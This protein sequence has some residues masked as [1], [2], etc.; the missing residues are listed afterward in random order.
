[1]RLLEELKI[2]C[3]G[4]FRLIHMGEPVDLPPS[5]KARALLSYLIFSG[6]PKRREHLCEMFWDTPHDPKG[7]LRWALSRLRNCLSESPR[8]RL[9]AD[10]ETITFN[11]KGLTSPLDH[12]KTRLD[13]L[14][15]DISELREIKSDL[16]K[17]FLDGVDLPNLSQ[18]SLWL[19]EQRT[20]VSR[21]KG[22]VLKRNLE[23]PNSAPDE[24]EQ[25]ARDWLDLE[26]FNPEAARTLVNLLLH[27]NATLEAKTIKEELEI[28]FR[29]AGIDFDVKPHT[30]PPLS[31]SI[32]TPKPQ[33][34]AQEKHLLARQKIQFCKTPTGV[35]LAYASVGD[36]PPLVKAANWLTHLEL[37]WTAPIWSPLYR[38]LAQDFT[39]IRYD[40]RGNGLSDWDVDELSQETF[41]KDLECVVDTMGLEKFPL[42]GIS[43]GAAVSIEY[44]IRHPERVSKLI[45]F[46]GYP[47]GWKIDASPEIQ[48]HN[49]AMMTLTKTGW[50][51][52]N[53]AY[54]HVFSST[55]MPSAS[56]EDLAWFDDFQRQTTS[57][58]NAVKFLEAFASIDVRHHLPNL[59]VPTL[60][61]HSRGDQRIKWQTGR[62]IA[63]EIPNAEFVSLDSDNH[64]L[65]EGEPAADKFIS[66]VREFLLE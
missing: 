45:L 65:L 15:L 35:N 44:A 6:E 64:L 30:P 50:G 13:S 11:M 4:E 32:P 26:P 1:M 37:D 38:E 41:V 51:Q 60:V 22:Q 20:E 10:R 34:H 2:N 55:F 12:M 36:G 63:A 28:R 47:K 24:S 56:A 66:A 43:Q 27:Q 59:K 5:K 7:S 42:L 8:Q 25:L 39:F 61:I 58:E 19:S 40:E 23:H 33:G 62:E 21:L 57:P 31:V 9:V 16:S 48:Q 14:R 52:N 18:F 29:D 46:G 49:E 17:T 53:P 54:R 3:F